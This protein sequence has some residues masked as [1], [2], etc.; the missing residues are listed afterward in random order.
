MDNEDQA[1]CVGSPLSSNAYTGTNN[2]STIGGHAINLIDSYRFK[3]IAPVYHPICPENDSIKKSE[4][5]N[6]WKNINVH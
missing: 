1:Y 4:I 6:W 3:K 5:L 2:F